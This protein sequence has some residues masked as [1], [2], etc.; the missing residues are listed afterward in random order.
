[1]N[2]LGQEIINAC[3]VLQF[4]KANNVYNSY[5]AVCVIDTVIL[6]CAYH[7]IEKGCEFEVCHIDQTVISPFN[8]QFPY[9]SGRWYNHVIS[10]SRFSRRRIDL[11]LGYHP[12]PPPLL[13]TT[14]FLRLPFCSHLN[15]KVLVLVL[16]TVRLLGCRDREIIGKIII[17]EG[18]IIDW[19][20]FS[21]SAFVLTCWLLA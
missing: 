15:N 14:P 16:I 12:P 21:V 19:F 5:C 20:E 13:L 17:L 10:V 6:K 1:M 11:F 18:R 3:Y 2:G 7:N 9:T 4:L 8:V